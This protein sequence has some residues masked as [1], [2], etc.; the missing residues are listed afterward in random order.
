MWNVQWVYELPTIVKVIFLVVGF[1]SC[2][3]AYYLGKQSQKE[4]KK[5]LDEKS[6]RSNVLKRNSRYYKECD[7]D[8]DAFLEVI[9]ST[10]KSADEKCNILM[11]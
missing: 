6:K 8:Y 11:N 7:E 4:E 5:P 3:C 9:N 10:D 2:V 1:I